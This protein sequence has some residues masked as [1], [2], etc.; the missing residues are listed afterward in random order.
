M[1]LVFSYSYAGVMPETDWGKR[2][3]KG[4]VKSMMLNWWKKLEDTIQC[5][6]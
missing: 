4:K 6:I 5:M 3:L 1:L 2:K